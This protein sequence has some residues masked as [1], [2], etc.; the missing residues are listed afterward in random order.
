MRRLPLSW[1]LGLALPL[2]LAE[3]ALRVLS[4]SLPSP[5]PWPSVGIEVKAERVVA[6]ADEDVDVVLL[7]SS[8]TEAGVDPDGLQQHAGLS[9]F[10]GAGPYST[11][12]S[13]ATWLDD[14]LWALDPELV[15]LG[16]PI[17]GAPD[18]REDDVLDNAFAELRAFEQSQQGVRG[19]SEL[20]SR[21]GQLRDLF[22][23]VSDT[24]TAASYTDRGHLTLY[25][26]QQRGD[27]APATGD[28]F[29]G[30]SADN[31]AAL[32]EIVAAAR[33]RGTEVV[34]MLEPGGCPPILPGCADPRSEA[35]A[36]AA[37]QELADSLDVA[38]LD[39]RR[40]EAEDGW[41]ADDAHFNR[42]GTQRFT[43]FLAGELTTL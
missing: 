19:N 39:G 7:G 27:A 43:E 23:L 36:R 20:W 35:D 37:V 42:E 9:A 24:A 33:S 14:Q 18:P 13:M 11:P 1:L 38:F 26:G 21:R 40:F 16:L 25:Y 12:V 10:N 2:L 3:G 41:Y 30:F 5:A 31:V 29:P 4:P 32:E 15:V 17:W 22:G 34:L 6:L 28:P 8:I